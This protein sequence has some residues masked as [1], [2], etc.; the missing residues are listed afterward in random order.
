MEELT[1]WKKLHNPDYLGAYSLDPGKDLIVTIKDVRKEIVTSGDGKKEECMVMTFKENGVKPMI[2]NATNAKQIQK[3]YRT[4]YI[5][6]WSGRKIQLYVEMVKAFGETVEALRI[7]RKIPA[8]ARINTTCSDCNK[9]IEPF[10]NMTAEQISQYT[11]NKYGKELCT[12]CAKKIKEAG[13][14]EDVL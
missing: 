6:Q 5:E 1:H 10:E 4:P 14:A 3:L 11:Y 8:A 13:I 9:P 7:R 12:E 2:V